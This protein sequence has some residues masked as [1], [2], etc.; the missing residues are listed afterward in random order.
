[1]ATVDLV[2]N[3]LSTEGYKYDID[4]DGDVHFKYEG[5]HLYF[6][7]DSNDQSFFRIIMPSIYQ[8][9]GNRTKV[10]EAANSVTRDLK[11]LKAFLVDDR[12]WL[13]IEM[14]LDAS[15]E[16]EDFFPRCLSLLKQ[17]REMI[18]QQIFG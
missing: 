14:F 13:T 11:V 12:L 15:P 6:T 8:V 3:W 17:G 18:A 7:V 16:L 5:V 4:S 10:L 2:K 1:M 9:D